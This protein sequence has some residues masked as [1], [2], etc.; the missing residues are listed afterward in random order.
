MK[1]W[2]QKI[3]FLGLAILLLSGSCENNDLTNNTEKT[4]IEP[5][6]PKPLIGNSD[7]DIS[8]KTV[9]SL[10]RQG[11]Q[12]SALELVS[13]IMEKAVKEQNQPQQIKALFY[14]LKYQ[15]ILEEDAFV[16][17]LQHI[18]TLRKTNQIPLT[19][20]LT[21]A[22]AEMLWNY[23]QNNRY[24]FYNRSTT[25]NFDL[26]DV[27]TWDLK[28]LLNESQKL[29]MASLENKETLQQIKL[30]DYE[31]ILAFSTD[32]GFESTPT[33][34]DFLAHRALRF[35]EN[36]EAGITR[37]ADKFT[38][39]DERFFGSNTDFITISTKTE[40]TLSNLVY[41]VRTMQ[42]LALFHANT[43]YIKA[44]ARNTLERLKFAYDKTT[45]DEK[46][47]WYEK[48]LLREQQRY[49]SD[50]I[51]AEINAQL[52]GLYIQLNQNSTT[53]DAHYN[54]AKKAHLLCEETMKQY[55][56]SYGAKLC[57]NLKLEI[58]KKSLRGNIEQ[59][60]SANKPILTQ[61]AFK[62]VSQ[63]HVYV[64]SL[65]DEKESYFSSLYDRLKNLKMVWSKKIELPKTDD[66]NEHTSEFVLDSLGYGSYLLVYSADSVNFD[67]N[68]AVCWA[69]NFQ[70]TDL[71][72]S[73]R[74]LS[75]SKLGIE[76][77]NRLTGQPISKATVTI[78][79]SSYNYSL[80]KYVYKK[81]GSFWTDDNG[82]ANFPHTTPKNYANRQIEVQKGSDK[83]S[84]DVYL[85]NKNTPDKVV[86]DDYLFTD[87]AIYRPGQ[88]VYFKGIRLERKDKVNKIAP[89]QSVKVAF[90][91][92]NYQ[93]VKELTLTSNEYGSYSG[94][95]Q[96]P[97]FG[98]TGQMTLQTNRGS[99]N[100]SV[101]EYKRPTFKVNF[102]TSKE[103]FKLGDKLKI[104][105]NATAYAGN[106]I[107]GALVSY[108]VKRSFYLP[109]WYAYRYRIMPIS[110]EATIILQGTTKT[111]EKGQF[112]ISFDALKDASKD[113][114]GLN[115]NYTIE[116]V[117]TDPNGETRTATKY[118]TLSDYSL[119]LNVSASDWDKSKVN[120]IIVSGT[121]SE[122]ENIP[123]KG[124]IRIYPLKPKS[125]GIT[126]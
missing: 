106:T 125:Q 123:I 101:E 56:N 117:V 59:Y 73:T 81:L 4:V 32:E 43:N 63:M 76:V 29:Y 20:I 37:P 16:K 28:T 110:Q 103:E 99:V 96:I 36:D 100:F 91:D 46:I 9:D 71:A 12:K 65:K 5:L 124:E 15:Q 48:A 104:N 40:D 26:G 111:D 25:A 1:N 72:F 90:K 58:E 60:V 115:Y 102:I 11:L 30:K 86:L 112:T 54:D 45:V 6:Q 47:N 74:N 39:N 114:N 84:S 67:K 98:L 62:N 10:D 31:Y 2:F 121:N 33:V 13:V 97:S 19:Q 108:V 22:K 122:G 23:F 35:F 52:V 89:N 64:Y 3:A 109:Y 8:W 75:S 118:I 44:R 27:T 85:Q 14:Q 80:R 113:Y 61:V 51:V 42:E 107:D 24:R 88:T 78:T 87:R 83:I 57:K 38:V 21:S 50:P 53:Q 41:Y 79:E 49:A 68:E 119:Q 116:A 95:F 17:A 77:V 126:V 105:G 93:D 70:V 66:F 82:W 120:S 92:A 7:Y 55:P 69:A 18:D 34:F 94:S